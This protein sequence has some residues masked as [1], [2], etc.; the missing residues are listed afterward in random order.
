[1]EDF[2]LSLDLRSALE[3]FIF[4]EARE[5]ELAGGPERSLA[6]LRHYLYDRLSIADMEAPAAYLAKLRAEGQ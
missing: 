2:N 3:L 6:A 1:V 4:L 5:G